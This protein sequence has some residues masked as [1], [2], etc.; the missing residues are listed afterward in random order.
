M[1]IKLSNFGYESLLV[2]GFFLKR[3]FSCFNLMY[4]LLMNRPDLL[5]APFWQFGLWKAIY[6]ASQPPCFRLLLNFFFA[7]DTLVNSYQIKVEFF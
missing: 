2:F 4:K 7:V 5:S 1:I 6:V 3:L